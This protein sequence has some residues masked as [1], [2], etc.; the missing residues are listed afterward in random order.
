MH[1]VGGADARIQLSTSGT[2][3]AA[4]SNNTVNIRGD[5]DNLKLNAAAN[6]IQVFEINGAE[7]ARINAQ[8]LGINY[9]SATAG[10][11]NIAGT[12]SNSV[13]TFF[14]HNEC[15]VSV[16]HSGA[17]GL[18]PFTI[19]LAFETNHLRSGTVEMDSSGHKYNNGGDFWHSRH[20]YTCMS[21]GS[22]N[23][24]GSR[25]SN[26]EFSQGAGRMTTALNKVSGS[27][28]WEAV[29]T[30]AG[31]YQGAFHFRLQGYGFANMPSSLS[32][33]TT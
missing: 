4:V 33:V 19:T 2:G 5:N 26:L 28:R 13:Q 27:N 9:T 15:F 29:M 7:K 22:N 10:K 20:V 32:V 17:A 16:A 8:G 14:Q 6:G 24:L 1:L 30:I 23:R 25:I 21:E 12:G 31:E 11:L 18:N 3:N